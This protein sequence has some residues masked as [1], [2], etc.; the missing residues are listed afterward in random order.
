MQTASYTIHGDAGT[1]RSPHKSVIRID[2]KTE[3]SDLTK[4]NTFRT[5]LEKY[6][7]ANVGKTSLA[8][9]SINNP[10][11]P[12]VSANLDDQGTIYMQDSNGDPVEITISAWDRTAY[13]PVLE[14]EGLRLPKT[15]IDAIASAL[16][17]LT[18]KTLMAVW[19]KIT[20]K[21]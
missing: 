21:T 18:G 20:T 7:L 4:L 6:T 12:G 11:A 13:P 2:M 5:E 9:S 1:G 17:T 19:G 10:T 3:V 14:S 8:W 16:S 15:T